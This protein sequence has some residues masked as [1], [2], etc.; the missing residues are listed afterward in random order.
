MKQ[1][2]KVG[3]IQSLAEC[4]GKQK[5]SGL[6][7][8][9]TVKGFT[10]YMKYR[11]ENNK[12]VK[13]AIKGIDNITDEKAYKEFN[14]IKLEI[15]NIKENKPIQRKRISELTTLN[16]MADYYFNNHEFK[17]KVNEQQRFNKHCRKEE[18]NTKLFV[19]ITFDEIDEWLKKLKLTK[20]AN[21]N[22]P[23]SAKT[24]SP[25][26]INN[27]LTLCI[28]IIKY[29]K[30]NRKYH[31]EVLFDQIKKPKVDNVRL[32]QM[33]ESEIELFFSKLKEED[34]N[35]KSFIQLGH[36]YGLL[37]LTLG[38][39]EQTILHIKKEDIDFENQIINL[40]NFKTE[41]K[42][43]GHIVNEEIEFILRDTIKYNEG[44]L[45]HNI[46]TGKVYKKAPAIVR[47]ILDKY[48]NINKQEDS[49]ITVR[50]LRNVF[51]TR[52]INKGM[53]LSLIQNLLNHK[54]PTMTARYAQ[55]MDTTG[56]EEL[57]AIFK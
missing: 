39:R 2:L 52:L 41:T 49:K 28:S 33:T 45:F 3:E 40:Y 15:S 51:A 34:I 54:T 24:L 19:L 21:I 11:D 14:R 18:F 35:S 48:I 44:F 31:G 57:K 23:K 50:D 27:I 53:S 47:N 13:K 12:V 10:Y 56:G 17:S 30:Q 38:A 16:E 26:S 43:L 1:D 25:K 8:K 55:M 46:L 7:I 9:R 42:Y 5:Y 6:L 22:N 36:L 29:A 20:P 4:I 37:A 32:K